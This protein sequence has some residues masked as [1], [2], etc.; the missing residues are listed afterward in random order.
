MMARYKERM[1]LYKME[2][3]EPSTYKN[4]LQNNFYDHKERIEFNQII[5]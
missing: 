4:I 3:I 2:R 5:F 1:E